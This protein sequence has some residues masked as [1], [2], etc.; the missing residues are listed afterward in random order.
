MPV[1]ISVPERVL[2]ISLCL[3]AGP[4]PKELG[5]LRQ[6]NVL[7]LGN[8]K[9]D[10]T[11]LASCCGR[12]PSKVVL[13][14]G[15]MYGFCSN[16]IFIIHFVLVCDL[17]TGAVPVELG[18]LDKLKVLCLGNNHLEGEFWGFVFLLQRERTHCKYI[19]SDRLFFFT[20]YS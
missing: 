16:V 7:M 3:A 6:L 9:L 19:F 18:T 12:L 5:G 13:L 10:G 14:C 8:N 15:R 4:I 1:S 11:L 2:P 20:T 17:E